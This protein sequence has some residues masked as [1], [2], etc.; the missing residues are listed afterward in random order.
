MS[1]PVL[2]RRRFIAAIPGM[3]VAL[4]GS[5]LAS[6]SAVL[7]GRQAALAELVDTLEAQ[8]GWEATN[9]HAA[10][11]FAAWQIRRVMGME[12]PDDGNAR[13]HV[14]F[15]R[16]CFERYRKSAWFEKDRRDG[17]AGGM[18]PLESIFPN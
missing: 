14:A 9:I 8:R 6:E 1:A 18:C 12:M 11:A 17:V 5:A 16:D 4:A 15:Q 13:Q 2:P 7:P 3:G 10:K